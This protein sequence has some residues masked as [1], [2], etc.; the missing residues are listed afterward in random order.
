MLN[1]NY[2][3]INVASAMADPDSVYWYYRELIQ[4]RK[5]NLIMPYGEFKL[6]WPED[7]D[8]FAFEKHLDDEHWFIVGNFSDKEIKVTLPEEYK[9]CS[10]VITTMKTDSLNNGTLFLG[11]YEAIV[12]RFEL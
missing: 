1:P 11:A 7:E 12:L 8:L 9:N 10:T 3:E 2:K 4:M 6:L 5:N